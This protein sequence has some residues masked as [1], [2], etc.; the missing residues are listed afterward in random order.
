MEWSQLNQAGSAQ[1]T[2]TDYYCCSDD[3]SYS[4]MPDYLVKKQEKISNGIY[5]FMHF[6]V[7][8]HAD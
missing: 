5:L 2:V 7:F 1:D 6:L 4:L 3:N 8:C